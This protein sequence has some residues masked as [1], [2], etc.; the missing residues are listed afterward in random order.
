MELSDQSH[1]QALRGEVSQL[2]LDT[3]VCAC[4]CQGPPPLAPAKAPPSQ[5]DSNPLSP[6]QRASAFT[7]K[8]NNPLAPRTIDPGASRG[9][10][11]AAPPLNAGGQQQQQQQ[12]TQH[13]DVSGHAE[14]SAA[15]QGTGLCRQCQ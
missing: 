7:A 13:S 12:Q 4:V 11:N 5:A 3:C 15:I 1:V 10:V 2:Y 6:T 8:A 9:K 14:T